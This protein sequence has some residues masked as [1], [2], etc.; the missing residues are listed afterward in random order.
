MKAPRTEYMVDYP[1]GPL[2]THGKICWPCN[3]QYIFSF[4]VLSA[5]SVLLPSIASSNRYAIKLIIS[6]YRGKSS[7]AKT[8]KLHGQRRS[9]WS[10]TNDQIWQQNKNAIQLNSY[11]PL[12][13]RL[14]K[15]RILCLWTADQTL[16]LSML[17]LNRKINYLMVSVCFVDLHHWRSGRLSLCYTTT[18]E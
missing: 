18:A 5:L 2:K 4:S 7:N 11:L 15:S 6:H 14:R 12:C 16:P 17:H 1:I 10:L 8:R 9:L 3:P 13:I